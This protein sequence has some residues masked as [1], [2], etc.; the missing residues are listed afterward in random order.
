MIIISTYNPQTARS[1][2]DESLLTTMLAALIKHSVRCKASALNAQDEIEKAHWQEEASNANRLI[3]IT[4][5]LLG[6]DWSEVAE[7]LHKEG[8]L[9]PIVTTGKT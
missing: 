6:L 3:G 9:W 1:T 8:K 4:F 2:E 7:L 5:P